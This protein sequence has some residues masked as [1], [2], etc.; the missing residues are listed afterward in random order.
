MINSTLIPYVSRFLGGNGGF[1]GV[2]YGFLGGNG[3]FLG[4]N[5]RT[6]HGRGGSSEIP[7]TSTA[8]AHS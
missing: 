7:L 4:E 8:M 3:G 1:L 2:Y 5:Y 6:Y